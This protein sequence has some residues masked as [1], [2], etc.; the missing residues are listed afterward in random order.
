MADNG[1]EQVFHSSSFFCFD[2]C[3]QSIPRLI[4]SCSFHRQV[5]HEDERNVSSTV[6]P[7]P[8]PAPY[9]NVLQTPTNL[10]PYD[11]DV[12]HPGNM[13]FFSY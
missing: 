5:S 6:G 11:W 10:Y 3:K 7:S 12:A 1:V 8:N 9:Y 2:F 4:A 13:F